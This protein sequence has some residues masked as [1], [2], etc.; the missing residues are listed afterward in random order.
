MLQST[1]RHLKG[2]SAQR[3]LDLWRQGVLTWEDLAV[4]V[5]PQFPLFKEEVNATCSS[6]MLSMSREALQVGDVA[7][8]AK[9]L[10]RQE[11]YRI[12][13][14]FPKETIFLDI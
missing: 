14:T 8:F 7:F 13:L 10:D 5:S 2:I 3:E 1:F 11:H 4:R 12:A 9:H 6:S